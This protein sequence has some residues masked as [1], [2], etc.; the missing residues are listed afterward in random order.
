MV[1]GAITGSPA[2]AHALRLTDQSQDGHGAEQLST[3]S[4]GQYDSASAGYAG[5]HAV[6]GA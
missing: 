6:A 5:A 4:R 3:S 1:T 2:C